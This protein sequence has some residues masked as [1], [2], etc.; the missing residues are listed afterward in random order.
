MDFQDQFA[1]FEGREIDGHLTVESS[2]S[3]ERLVEDIRT[4]GRSHDD[5]IGLI[6][7]SI[8]LREDLVECLFSLIMS[9]TDSWRT[10][11]PYRIDL[12]DEYDGRCLLTGFT[13]E[14]SD[15]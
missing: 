1:I 7:E 11:L 10:L 12:I 4:V 15:T 9:A 8:H 5:H 2:W 3:Q 6:V 14:V 13:E